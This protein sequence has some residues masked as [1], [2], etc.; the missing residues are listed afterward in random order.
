MYDYHNNLTAAH[1]ASSP[2]WAWP[3]DLKPV[4]F[5]QEGFA[6][7]TIGGDLRR[8]QPR[9]LVAR[10]PGH[11]VRRRGRRSSA[12]SLGAGP[13]RDRLRRPVDPVGADRPGGV[14]VPL[15]HG[16]AVRDPRPRLL[17]RRAVARRVAPD[18]AARPARGRG[19]DRRARRSCG[20][21][22]RPL[23]AFVGVASVNPDS[24]A[25]P[26]LIPRVRPDGPDGRPRR[27][28]SAS[29][30]LVFLRAPRRRSDDGREPA[31]G[32]RPPVLGRRSG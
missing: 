12:A 8:R 29:A 15:L 10:R 3:F 25:C 6:G 18:L 24:Q 4:W 32:R 22:D 1:A 21:F 14:P 7:G 2:W 9:H 20:C 16:A 31:R 19:R 30:S 17:R 23:C 26:P 11:G 13:H 27:S 28:S 5:Y